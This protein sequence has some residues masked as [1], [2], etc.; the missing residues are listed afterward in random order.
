MPVIQG[1]KYA[2]STDLASLGLIGGALSNVPTA[3]QDAALI[4]A[5]ALADSYLQ[6]RYDLPITRWGQDLARAVC[7]IAAYDLLTS[8]GFGMVQGPDANIR[9]RYLDALEWL[10]EVSQGKQ[11]PAYV[12]DSSVNIGTGGTAVD[13]SVVT[14]TQGGIQIVT[15]DVRGWTDR[16]STAAPFDRTGWSQ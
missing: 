14:T 1:T 4:A 15:Q 11:T 6:S 16:G 2:T 10:Q 12:I 3:T 8:R 13:G 5:S 9:Q 7:Q